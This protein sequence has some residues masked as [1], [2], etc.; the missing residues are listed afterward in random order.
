MASDATAAEDVQKATGKLKGFVGTV[1]GLFHPFGPK[2]RL[3]NTVSVVALLAGI[4]V[5][6]ATAGASL[7]VTTVFNGAAMP[8]FT[9]FWP[10]L[11]F[12]G[13]ET[14]ASAWNGAAY[15]LGGVQHIAT[16]AN[17]GAVWTG[18]TSAVGALSPTGP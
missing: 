9:S 15:L 11:G 6:A 8:T 1:F 3:L 18:I 7:P 2:G 14:L 12:V 17:W 10:G 4:G 13:T 5:A 16:S